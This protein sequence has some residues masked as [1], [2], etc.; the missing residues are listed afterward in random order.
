MPIASSVK[1]GNRAIGASTVG[2]VPN[3]A[4][5]R[6]AGT[7]APSTA[8]SPEPVPRSPAVCHVSWNVT[9]AAS[10]NITCCCGGSAATMAPPQMYRQCCVPLPHIHRPVAR[11]P[12]S[13]T[14]AVAFGANTPPVTTVGSP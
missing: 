4:N 5:D 8:K 7:N 13:T 9:S 6:P 3:A 1:L 10:K 11:Q 12:P 14:S 2:R